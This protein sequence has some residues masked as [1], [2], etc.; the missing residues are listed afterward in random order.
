MK[1]EKLEAA[2][3][4][5]ACAAAMLVL[6]QDLFVWAKDEPTPRPVVEIKSK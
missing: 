3:I 4:A 6:Y 5:I 1:I 2:I